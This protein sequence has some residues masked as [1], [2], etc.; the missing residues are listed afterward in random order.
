MAGSIAIRLKEPVFE[1]QTKNKLG[2]TE[3]RG[4]LVR[5]VQRVVEDL[6][7]RDPKRAELVVAKV[8]DTEVLR[9]ELQAVKKMARERAKSVSLRIPQLKDCKH[10]L[11]KKREKGYG[12][13]VFLCE[14][15][16]AAGSNGIR[17]GSGK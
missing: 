15:Q 4:E 17:S 2:N 16:S 7:H 8:R 3:I 14:G 12:T 9:K 10:H 11:D 5:E 13:M 6:L 1:S